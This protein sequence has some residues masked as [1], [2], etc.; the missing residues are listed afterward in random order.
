MSDSMN[1]EQNSVRPVA[2]IVALALMALLL[3][4]VVFRV[5]PPAPK[6]VEAPADQFS[7]GRVLVLLKEILAEG[8]PHISGSEQHQAVGQGIV[9]VFERLG[10]EVEVQTEMVCRHNTGAASACTEIQ[11]IITR[12]PGRENGPALMLTAHYDSMPATAGAADDGM[13]VAGILEMARILKEQGP[14]RNP[15]VFLITDAEELGS[16]GAEGFVSDHPWAEDVAVVLNQEARGTTGQSFMFETSEENG[17]LVEAYAAAV[18]RPASSSLHYE[19]YRIMPNNSDLTIFRT[20]GMAGMNFGF[21]G[22]LSHY[23]T[24]LDNFENLDLGSVQH[25]GESLLAVAQELA[26]VD[27]ANP[28]TGGAAWTDLLGITVVRWPTSWNI[29]LAILALIL[30][31]VVAGRLIRRQLV[32]IGGLLLGLLTAFLS[33]VA[34]IVAGLLLVWFVSLVTGDRY[35]YYAYP[36]PIRVSVWA[37]ALLSAG[38]ITTATVRR[39][40]AW[41]LAIGGWLLWALLAL[42]LG[43][44]LPGAA[45]MLLLPTV[46]AAILFAIVAFSRLSSSTPAREV[47]F[48]A[49]AI[50]AGVVWLYLSLIFEVAVGFAMSP[51]I[52]LGLGLVAGALAPLFALP[53]EQT[54]ARRGLLLATAITMILAT[55]IA[56]LV[57]PFSASDPQQVNISHFD[58]RTGGNAYWAA[59]SFQGEVPEPL[60]GLF[61]TDLVAVFPW[62]G[63]TFPVSSTQSTAAPAPY[64]QVI[65]EQVVAGERVITGQLYSPRGADSIFL[66]VPVEA[67][68][69]IVIE[70]NSFAVTPEGDWNGYYT[71]LCFGRA[72]EGLTVQLHLKGA[73]PVEVLVVDSIY[74]LP[75]GG[76]A[77]T[78]ARPSTAVPANMGDETIIMTRMEL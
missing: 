25:Q 77:F 61:D 46:L 50:G 26:E 62:I 54:R 51:A 2:L 74:D 76:E 58:D 70:D 18:P 38:L 55:G 1:Q 49:A 20:D 65:S 64:L 28:P 33:L 59:A 60:R 10:Y 8:S 31:L 13:A 41:G 72:C 42:L 47:A 69:S 14:F 12:L 53:Q 29:P 27:L 56:L 75:P 67:L 44:S 45:I 11:N 78:Q 23:H 16:L 39:C 40:G 57:P 9:A 36:L 3:I 37:A 21:I 34:A 52:T 48:I 4:F 66:H 43:L 22:R 17:W 30:L 24:P 32:T 63:D 73:T 5:Q 15:I 19:I 68:A 71:L 6:G 7:A 35:P